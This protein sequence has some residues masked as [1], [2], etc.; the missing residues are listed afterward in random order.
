MEPRLGWKEL[1]KGGLPETVS[2]E[3]IIHIIRHYL[4]TWAS[5][6]SPYYG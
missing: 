5:F 4:E 6:L 1:V 3:I 2:A